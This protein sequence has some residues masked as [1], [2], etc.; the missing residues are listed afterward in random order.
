MVEYLLT[1]PTAGKPLGTG[2]VQKYW[3][4]GRPLV[5]SGLCLLL[6]P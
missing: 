1:N 4:R 3:N 6:P 2:A 5:A